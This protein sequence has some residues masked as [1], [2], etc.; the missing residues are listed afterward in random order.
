MPSKLIDILGSAGP[1]M[2]LTAN[3]PDVEQAIMT[4]IEA[5]QRKINEHPDIPYRPPITGKIDS[6][7]YHALNYVRSRSIRNSPSEDKIEAIEKELQ[8]M[9]AS[10]E[11]VR[12]ILRN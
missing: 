1:I 11:A 6:H 2:D 9:A 5:V 8:Y 7:T 12:S 10:I 3:D 4:I